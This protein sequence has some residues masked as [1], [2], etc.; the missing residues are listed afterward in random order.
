MP[1]T[2]TI[3][4]KK[5]VVDHLVIMIDLLLMKKKRVGDHL[6]IMIDLLLMKKRVGDHLVIMITAE[7]T[8]PRF[9]RVFA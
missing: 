5:R 7:G 2:I 9:S 1:M 4:T 3:T 8:R 6:V